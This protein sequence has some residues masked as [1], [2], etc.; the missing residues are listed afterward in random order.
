MTA[1][2]PENRK[3]DNDL[4][5]RET[6]PEPGRPAGL[7]KIVN[8]MVALAN[9]ERCQGAVK[10]QDAHGAWHLVKVSYTFDQSQQPSIAMSLEIEISTWICKHIKGAAPIFDWDDVPPRS[11]KFL[12]DERW[13]VADCVQGANL[14]KTGL[15]AI[16]KAKDRQLSALER[17]AMQAWIGS[18]R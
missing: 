7:D 8:A 13:F 2:V 11:L 10:F 14:A 17:H 15:T 18:I 4:I 1:L 3:M 5:R 16:K 6:Q 12:L 9:T